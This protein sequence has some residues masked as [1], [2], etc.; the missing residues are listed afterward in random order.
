MLPLPF[1]FFVSFHTACRTSR[2]V[3]VAARAATTP[4]TGLVLCILVFETV[5]SRLL[6]KGCWL[7][8]AAVRSRLLSGSLLY[9][10]GAVS[11]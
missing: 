10:F 6:W 9:S 3:A 7:L 11:L 8:F 2:S 4:S 1:R 5:R